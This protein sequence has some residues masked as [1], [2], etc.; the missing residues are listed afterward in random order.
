[1]PIRITSEDHLTA[2]AAE[3]TPAADG[4]P[5]DPNPGGDPAEILYVDERTGYPVSRAEHQHK[6]ELAR[7]RSGAS[8]S[9]YAAFR[10]DER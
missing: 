7:Q 10:R 1:M 6:R 9:S 3:H 8:Q 2:L 5:H 4:D